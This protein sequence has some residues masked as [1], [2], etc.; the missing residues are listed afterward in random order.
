VIEG[1]GGKEEEEDITPSL[2]NP[3]I[4]KKRC[5]EEKGMNTKIM[6]WFALTRID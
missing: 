2:K 6:F 3:N 1:R 5:S 4:R